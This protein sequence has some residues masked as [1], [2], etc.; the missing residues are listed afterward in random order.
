MKV[1]LA[2]DEEELARAIGAILKFNNYEVDIVNDGESA[3]NQ[4]MKKIYDILILDV[5]M[6]KKTGI[7]V[8]KEIREKNIEVPVLMLTAKSEVEDKIEGLDS[9]ANDYLTKPFNK[10]EL[11]AR[12][13][14]I[15][16]PNQGKLKKIVIG[17]VTLDKEEN[18]LYTDKISF[19]LNNKE[20][21][22][23]ETL[24]NYQD[25]SIKK[26]DLKNR[27]WGKDAEEEVVN[28]YINYLQNKFQALGANITIK[29]NDGY[30]L[31]K[32]L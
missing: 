31:E 28:V 19:Q 14:A 6:P 30:S 9:G 26:E 32:R 15:T 1:L 4:V 7:Q 2:D 25:K 27:I 24:I 5:M 13:R 29:E 20:C 17:N 21:Q 23:L 8:V 11:L 10:D 18:E 3:L 22:M 16:R 12:L